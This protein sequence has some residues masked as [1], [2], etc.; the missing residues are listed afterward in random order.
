M[1]TFLPYPSFIRSACVLD[2]KRLGNQRGETKQILITLFTGRDAW[3]NHPAVLMWKGYENSLCQYGIAVCSEWIM[4]GFK[5]HQFEWFNSKIDFFDLIVPPWL[6]LEQLHA[7]HR[8]NLLRK[9]PKWYSQFGWTEPP[10]LPYYW[11][12][13]KADLEKV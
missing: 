10:Y 1:Q 8:S 12:V 9:D 3:K 5:D 4:R 6:G 7:S 11:P 2:N 13:K